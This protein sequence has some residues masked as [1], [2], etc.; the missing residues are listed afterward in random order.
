MRNELAFRTLS[1]ADIFTVLLRISECKWPPTSQHR[2]TYVVIDCNVTM[3]DKIAYNS[4]G[5]WWTQGR[6]AVLVSPQRF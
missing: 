5:L 2:H 4:T 1:D 6:I 3:H